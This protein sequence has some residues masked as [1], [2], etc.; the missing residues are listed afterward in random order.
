[1]PGLST[2][3]VQELD[4]GTVT[5]TLSYTY[6]QTCFRAHYVYAH[7]TGTVS[8]FNPL[9]LKVTIEIV[10]RILDCFGNNLEIKNDFTNYLKKSSE[11]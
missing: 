6:V 8:T 11:W 1:M 5:V 2:Y 3:L 10:V 4:A 7:N 9:M